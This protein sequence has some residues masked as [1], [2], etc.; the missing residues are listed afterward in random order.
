MGKLYALH[1]D[2]CILSLELQR[3]PRSFLLLL[4][5]NIQLVLTATDFVS[6]L[7]SISSATGKNDIALKIAELLD[8]DLAFIWVHG[9]MDFPGNKLADR[10]ATLMKTN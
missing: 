9:H 4:R 6:T 7:K 8:P 3:T 1:P 2:C 5:N 10:A